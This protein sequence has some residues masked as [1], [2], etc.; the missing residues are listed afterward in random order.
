ML[1]MEKRGQDFEMQMEKDRRAFE[2]RLDNSNKGFLAGLERE[3]REWEKDA[4]KWPKR[5]IWAAII[6]AVAEVVSNVPAIQ[7]LLGLD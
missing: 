4:G 6:L 7:R 3:R 2:E 5:L 1:T